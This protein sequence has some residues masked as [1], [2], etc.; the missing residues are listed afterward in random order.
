VNQ[1]EVTIVK[2]GTF[3]G[4]C[5]ELCGV[6]H[7]RMNFSVKVVPQAEFDKYIAERQAAARSSAAGAPALTSGVQGSA[8]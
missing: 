4:R 7:D 8:R 3:V 1:F 2:T 6:D 5:A